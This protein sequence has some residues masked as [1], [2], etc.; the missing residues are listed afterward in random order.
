MS[1]QHEPRAPGDSTASIV[2]AFFIVVIATVAI[3][4]AS[5][6]IYIPGY[7]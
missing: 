4:L 3:L 1:D 2:V 6:T 5:G 7:R